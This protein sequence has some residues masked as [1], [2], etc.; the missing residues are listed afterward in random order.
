MKITVDSH[1]SRIALNRHPL[2]LA[3]AEVLTKNTIKDYDGSDDMDNFE[4][5]MNFGDIPADTKNEISQD[6]Y[7]IY[8]ESTNDE[9]LASMGYSTKLK[10][11]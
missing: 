3:L 11:F 1:R 5:M 6:T 8:L 7:F 4:K 2:G 10:R 9:E